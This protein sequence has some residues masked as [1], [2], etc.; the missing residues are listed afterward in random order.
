MTKKRRLSGSSFSCWV[1]DFDLLSELVISYLIPHL[2]LSNL[3]IWQM[4]SQRYFRRWI[5]L[6]ATVESSILYRHTNHFGLNFKDLGNSLRQLQ[7]VRWNILKYAKTKYQG[8]YIIT[9]TQ[10]QAGNIGKGRKF[11]PS[12]ELES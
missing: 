1:A 11:A 10:D 8:N 4:V 2:Y 9:V 12:L 7:V 5:G 6:N 3:S